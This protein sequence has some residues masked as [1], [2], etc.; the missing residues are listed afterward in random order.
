M[1]IKRVITRYKDQIVSL[2]WHENELMKLQV[3]PDKTQYVLGDIYMGRVQNVVKNISAAFVEIAKDVTCFLQLK[4]PMCPVKSNTTISHK[5]GKLHQG[6]SF[7]V[8]IIRQPQKSKQAAVTTEFDLTGKYLVL[9]HG[10]TKMS[11]SGKIQ[12][13]K[14]RERLLDILQRFDN[15]NYGFIARTNAAFVEESVIIREAETLHKQ[16]E[17]LL[18]TAVY[19]KTGQRVYGALPDYVKEL[20]PLLKEE[21][22]TVITDCEDIKKEVEAYLPF[23]VEFY[24]DTEYP[25]EKQ[26]GLS[27]VVEKLLRKKVWLKSGAYIVI[28]PTEA[29]VSIDVNTGKAIEG[30]KA[31]EDTFYKINLEA[32]KEIA[33]QIRLRNLSGLLLL[34]FID[35]KEEE[36]N[37]GILKLLKKEVAK[38]T[39]KTVVVDMTKLGLVE[40]TRKKVQKPIHEIFS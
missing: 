10:K 34:D 32:A 13:G 40:M 5:D 3:S 2:E 26:Y 17:E 23:P 29:L 11:V 31:G 25:L 18:H 16:Y 8:Q 39:V 7:L 12:D 38:D 37:T 19:A 15:E 22:V 28:E 21:D 33:R 30:K 9:T 24:E 36:H 14:E 4:E 20:Q 6:D 27:T 1:S 35:M